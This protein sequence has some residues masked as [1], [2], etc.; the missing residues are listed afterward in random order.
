MH[1]PITWHNALYT[2]QSHD[3]LRYSQISQLTQIHLLVY[4]FC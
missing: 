3:A 1:T 4:V 2:N